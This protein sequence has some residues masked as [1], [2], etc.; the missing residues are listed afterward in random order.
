MVRCAEAERGPRWVVVGQEGAMEIVR[1]RDL[2][3]VAR[4]TGG[5]AGKGV[6]AISRRPSVQIT[7]QI[8]PLLRKDYQ[9][10]P[11]L[12]RS[13]SHQTAPP[14]TTL[15]PLNGRSTE[16]HIRQC[17]QGAESTIAVSSVQQSPPIA[18]TMDG[19]NFTPASTWSQTAQ[20][21]PQGPGFESAEVSSARQQVR[22]RRV[23]GGTRGCHR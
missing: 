2:S 4:A 19:F 13:T 8:R 22:E 11:H 6:G 18:T 5:Q 20:F 14:T 1:L 17:K 12:I 21:L 3:L 9:A 16:E 10:S 23:G 7:L 15:L